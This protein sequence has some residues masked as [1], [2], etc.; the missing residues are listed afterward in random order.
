M[1]LCICPPVHEFVS[2][3]LCLSLVHTS[4]CMQ[5]LSYD[6]TKWNQQHQK[7]P[8]GG[9]QSNDMH[10][11]P[12]P[13]IFVLS[14]RLFFQYSVW[15]LKQGSYYLSFLELS[16]VPRIKCF[17]KTCLHFYGKL[18]LWTDGLNSHR[19]SFMIVVFLKLSHST[20]LGNMNKTL[21]TNYGFFRKNKL[22][23]V[24]FPAT[25]V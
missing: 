1:R 7:M 12:N 23:T 11:H 17:G 13:L 21:Q 9:L 25:D 5:H 19:L 2:W 14:K 8:H 6:L 15:A 22:H 3:L 20:G 18:F 10:V 16:T 4:L 24:C